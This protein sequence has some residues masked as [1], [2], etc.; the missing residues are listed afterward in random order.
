MISDKSDLWYSWYSTALWE[1]KPVSKTSLPNAGK[2]KNTKYTHCNFC[3]EVI[4]KLH[5]FTFH[6]IIFHIIF[7]FCYVM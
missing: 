3:S 6:I 7:I 4:A 5:F 1:T 2:N